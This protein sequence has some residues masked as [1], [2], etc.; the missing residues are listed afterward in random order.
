MAPFGRS[1]STS[2][3][4]IA[5]AMLVLAYAAYQSLFFVVEGGVNAII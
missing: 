3:R 2:R 1:S 5:A 4:A